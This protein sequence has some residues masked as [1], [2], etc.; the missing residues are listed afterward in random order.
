MSYLSFQEMC[1]PP[2]AWTPAPGGTKAERRS[3]GNV[4]TA[5]SSALDRGIPC[6]R[7][8]MSDLSRMRAKVPHSRWHLRCRLGCL[9]C[10]EGGGSSSRVTRS[11]RADRCVPRGID[12]PEPARGHRFFAGV[13]RARTSGSCVELKLRRRNTEENRRCPSGRA[14]TSFRDDCSCSD[15]DPGRSQD[16]YPTAHHTK[17]QGPA[18]GAFDRGWSAR[19]HRA[20]SG[21]PERG[22]CRFAGEAERLLGVRPARWISARRQHPA[23]QSADLVRGERALHHLAPGWARGCDRSSGAGRSARRCRWRQRDGYGWSRRPNWS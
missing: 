13:S 14:Q 15:R 9:A 21:R 23:D 8:G 3:P 10:R 22:P 2:R 18:R 7:R 19:P 20:C 1:A 11:P 17:A 5:M 12:T 16:E 4:L 6:P